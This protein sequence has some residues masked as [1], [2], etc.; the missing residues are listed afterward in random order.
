MAPS[1][2]AMRS[3]AYKMHDDRDDRQNQKNMNQA[4]SDVEDQ[5]TENP[6]QEQQNEQNQEH[7]SHG[8]LLGEAMREAARSHISQ[9]AEVRLRNALGAPF[10]LKQTEE[11]P[12]SSR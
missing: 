12:P 9:K 4:A 5:E 3:S 2:A 8:R 6:R 11:M 1:N 10:N 7:E